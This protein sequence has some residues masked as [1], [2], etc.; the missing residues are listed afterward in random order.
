MLRNAGL[1]D[2]LE[3]ESFSNILAKD[4][5]DKNAAPGADRTFTLGSFHMHTMVQAAFGDFRKRFGTPTLLAKAAVVASPGSL[6]K[7]SLPSHSCF[8]PVGVVITEYVGTLLNTPSLHSAPVVL[9]TRGVGF[10]LGGILLPGSWRGAPSAGPDT[11]SC[12]RGWACSVAQQHV[13]PWIENA[14]HPTHRTLLGTTRI[15]PH[16]GLDPG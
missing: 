4:Q 1:N 14:Q 11:T 13:P 16:H 7:Q 9:I 3:L 8:G 15:P 10:F 12:R 6:N 5:E 2:V